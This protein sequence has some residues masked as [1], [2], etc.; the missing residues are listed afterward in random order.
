MKGP[1]SWGRCKKATTPQIRLGEGNF[2][3]AVH[4][5]SRAYLLE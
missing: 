5:V 2:M 3:S 4:S 1:A